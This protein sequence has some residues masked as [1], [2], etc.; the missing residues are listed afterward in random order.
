ME[1]W[2]CLYDA[3]VRNRSGCTSD[4]FR[5]RKNRRAGQ[6]TRALAKQVADEIGDTIH[7][8]HRHHLQQV[9]LRLKLNEPWS[10]FEQ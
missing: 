3:A 1:L 10:C 4:Y 2:N 8:H 6:A 7:G 9:A 5:A